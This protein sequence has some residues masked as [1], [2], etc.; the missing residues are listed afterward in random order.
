[1]SENIE[2]VYFRWMGVM[3]LK[4]NTSTGDIVKAWGNPN[5]CYGYNKC[6][7]PPATYTSTLN[8]ML[9]SESSKTFSDMQTEYTT[10]KNI[11][12]DSETTCYEISYVDMT[13]WVKSLN[14]KY[15]KNIKT[16]F[17]NKAAPE[18]PASIAGDDVFYLYGVQVYIFDLTK[19]KVY[20][21]I[22]EDITSIVNQIPE[23][24]NPGDLMIKANM[25]F[26]DITKSVQ[27]TNAGEYQIF[28]VETSYSL[29]IIPDVPASDED[30]YVAP[31]YKTPDNKY[32]QVI[33]PS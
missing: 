15:T 24:A 25:E 17:P 5:G 10:L 23:D 20:S 33:D 22:D 12:E 9:G 26:P 32:F 14:Y 27:V 18:L 2:N 1:V 4:F 6:Y 11:T 19:N 28:S 31:V 13:T 29:G 21:V 16:V 8:E 3:D 7:I 30:P